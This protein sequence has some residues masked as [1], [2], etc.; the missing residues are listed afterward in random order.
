MLTFLLFPIFA[1]ASDWSDRVKEKLDQNMAKN[2]QNQS[3]VGVV[4]GVKKGAEIYFWS[5][6]K[7]VRGGG[8]LPTPDTFFEMGS[9]TKTYTATLLARE[10]VAGTLALPDS[11]EKLWPELSGT[12][13]G[14]ITLEQLATHH[15]GLPR[16]PE[17]FS[18]SDDLDPYRDFDDQKLFNYLKSFRQETPGPYPYVYSNLAVGLL[19]YLLSQKLHGL[20][21]S[22]YLDQT[23][24]QP[25]RLTDTKTSITP[26][27][28]NRAAQGYDSFFSEIPFW[29]LN[30]LEGAG[31][32]KTTARDLLAYAN[33]QMHPGQDL[34]GQAISLT[35]QKR[36][37]SDQPGVGVGL[38]WGLTEISGHKII[39]HN[40]ATG[41]YR[42]NFIAAPGEDL[43]AIVL[44]DTDSSPRCALAPIFDL[45]CEV[46][47]WQ[48]IDPHDQEKFLGQ[49][50]NADLKWTISALNHRGFFALQL[51]G[52][53]PTRLWARSVNRYEIPEQGIT[54]DFSPESFNLRMDNA[55]YLFLRKPR[56]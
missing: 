39:N 3:Q 43:A 50:Y 4:V 1:F 2:F 14:K 30:V 40:G 28:Q 24:L 31:V 33:A 10:V 27:D 44:S 36:A 9:I 22:A 15:S 18:A 34:L 5:Y 38:I 17:N 12:D 21:Y 29:N 32:L 49:F 41:G 26:A 56:P 55:D 51:E 8:E 11:V 52:Q 13:A 42:A 7:R 19:G 23:L 16:M 6:G 45:P 54:V 25:L 46:P 20:P 48:N 37:D 35:Q 47:Q 53:T